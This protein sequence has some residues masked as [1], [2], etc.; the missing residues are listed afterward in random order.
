MDCERGCR[1]M[2]CAT[3]LLLFLFYSATW[4]YIGLSRVVH[5][6][7]SSTVSNGTLEY[8]L[9]EGNAHSNLTLTLNSDYHVSPGLFCLTQSITDLTIS[10]FGTRQY[11]V[12]C[13]SSV[14]GGRRGFGFYNVTNLQIT[15][16]I[17]ENCGGTISEEAVRHVNNTQFLY[18]EPGQKA[19][20]LF[21]HC[22]DV[23]LENVSVLGYWGFGIVGA[24]L[25]G[26]A[27][28]T[29]VS[30]ATS[31]GVLMCNTFN[32]SGGGIFLFYQDSDIVL[33]QS[34]SLNAVINRN[35]SRGNYN[36][37][38][39]SV[40]NLLHQGITSMPAIGASGLTMIFSQGD[41]SVQTNIWCQFT[42]G[43]S[44]QTGTTMVLFSNDIAASLSQ[45]VFDGVSLSGNSAQEL[46]HGLEMAILFYSKGNR[47][48]NTI[49]ASSPLCPVIIRNASF[50]NYQ[51]VLPR[52]STVQASLF[53]VLLF[54]QN[55]TN[56][57]VDITNLTFEGNRLLATTEMILFYSQT[58]REEEHQNA[59]L[60][61]TIQD[62]RAF[63][64]VNSTGLCVT[65]P[66]TNAYSR[67]VL[68]SF[69][70]LAIVTIHG[71]ANFSRNAA[72]SILYS[73]STD[74]YL[75]GSMTFEDGSAVY[76]AAIRLQGDSHIFLQEPLHA[77][78]SNNQA[79]QGGAI[80]GLNAGDDLCIF[81][82]VPQ[83]VCHDITSLNI[84][85]NFT[86]NSAVIV[87]NSVYTGPIYDCAQVYSQ[88]L[89]VRP[90]NYSLLY[91]Q[92]F[93]FNEGGTGISTGQQLSSFP[94]QAC[95]CESNGT[96]AECSNPLSMPR[97]TYPGRHLSFYIAVNDA[98]SNPVYCTVIA[99]IST[100]PGQE[101]FPPVRW[102]LGEAELI[103]QLQNNHCS[104]LNYTIFNLTEVEMISEDEHT[105]NIE[106]V[107]Q[108]NVVGV[109]LVELKIL[110][111]PPGFV[112][113]QKSICDCIPLLISLR[114]T[115]DINTGL[116][117]RPQNSWIGIV[118]HSRDNTSIV[119]FSSPCPPGYCNP[120]LTQVNISDPA[121]ICNE[122]RTGVL[123][124][125]CQSNLSIVFGSD[126]CQECS[127]AW[128]STIILY[129]AA[130]IILVGLLFSLR[131]TVANGMI[132][133]LIF[134]AN[135]TVINVESFVGH[136]VIFR[137][138]L[139]FINLELGFPLCFTSGMNTLWKTGLQFVFPVYLWALVILLIILSRRS[140]KI[141]KLVS[142][143]SVQVL[144]TLFYLSYS[145]LL[146][147]VIYILTATTVQQ[148]DKNDHLPS[149]TVWFYDGSVQFA[150]GGH[151]V[152]LLLALLTAIFLLLPYT[153]LLTGVSFFMKYRLVNRFKPLIDAYHGPYKD[154]WRLWFG[155]RLWIL[156]LMF[157]IQAVLGGSN[158]PL[159]F[160]LHLLVL[161]V[162]LLVQA[163]IKP[164]RNIF[165][166]LLDIF[167]MANYCI[168]AA[169]GTYFLLQDNQLPL[170][171]VAGIL[172]GIAFLAFLGIAA[173]HPAHV[174]KRKWLERRELKIQQAQKSDGRASSPAEREHTTTYQVYT[175]EGTGEVVIHST[176]SGQSENEMY[177]SDRFRDSVLET[178]DN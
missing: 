5:I 46:I 173:Y 154:K 106:M 49:P 29:D 149:T 88:R 6:R 135:I 44:T 33:N 114:I 27:E 119:G 145:K 138:F 118:E 132:N 11:R 108:P 157:G 43:R 128:V 137:I 90:E 7:G 73:Y 19:A 72:G 142:K 126:F 57:F 122:Q 16:I 24:N 35:Y 110:D 79:T 91:E 150:S 31:R 171:I 136:I 98:N 63:C 117:S 158:V 147:T 105:V 64:N 163:S 83:Q 133:G 30:V 155:V 26:N 102:R 74:L 141:A 116:V 52:S 54:P 82:F 153:I 78:F 111:C 123:C 156:L 15:N 81:Q 47:N 164:F 48:S 169:I 174:V 37:A 28:F 162:F 8:Y 18:V 112:V 36:C 55:E 159:A 127:N 60:H 86:Q 177:E 93:N 96:V 125:Q 80:Y 34:H 23:K 148:G 69:V 38:P 115:C 76:G 144:A 40:V 170:Q 104:S 143:S 129:V 94:V 61:I 95:M 92:V 71:V 50:K 99:T 22:L 176:N 167:F 51:G 77:M 121:T 113:T 100:N 45:V 152:L 101:G 66:F 13:N 166:G 89:N 109:R 146:R 165:V 65:P 1:R 39:R 175:V 12:Y 161:G 14:T 84:R 25:E 85:L 151:V 3:F 75:S 139:S 172:V 97:E 20:I 120:N 107:I 21:N 131:M 67:A 160:L 17:F 10:S 168:L 58:I 56:Y 62:V 42:E 130:G 59:E 68:F 103:A 140:T 2:G 178:I 53:A 87:G 134:Y 41:Y 9:C 124:S 70:N 32:E 4:P